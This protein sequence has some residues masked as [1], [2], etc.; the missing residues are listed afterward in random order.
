MHFHLQ[1][2]ENAVLRELDVSALFKVTFSKVPQTGQRNTLFGVFKNTCCGAEIV[3][4]TG[5]VFPACPEHP[6]ASTSWKPIEVGPDNV[7]ELSTKKSKAD[8]AA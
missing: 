1:G 8:P 3:I 6:Q 7:T 5:T 2:I 4:T